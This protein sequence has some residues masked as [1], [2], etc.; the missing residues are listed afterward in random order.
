VRA[1]AGELRDSR[2][3]EKFHRAIFPQQWDRFSQIRFSAFYF[4]PRR[5][6]PVWELKVFDALAYFSY[7]LGLAIGMHAFPSTTDLS[8]LWHQAPALARK[9]N[10]LA[11]ISL[12]LAGGLVILN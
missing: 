4:V 10:I 11:I 5:F 8:H 9:G 3:D 12:P 1:A 2:A 7:W 6:L